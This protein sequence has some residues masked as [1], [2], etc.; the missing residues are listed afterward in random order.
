M[1]ISTRFTGFDLLNVSTITTEQK[2]KK[3]FFS[4]VF[5]TFRKLIIT[6]I[7]TVRKLHERKINH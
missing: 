6:G 3:I 4:D 7:P 5:T 1:S 2:L